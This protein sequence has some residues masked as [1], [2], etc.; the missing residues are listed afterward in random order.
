MSKKRRTIHKPP[1]IKDRVESFKQTISDWRAAGF[2]IAD[3]ERHNRRLKICE[4]CEFYKNIPTGFICLKC[5]C[6]S[7]KLWL[8]TSKCPINKW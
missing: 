8:Q 2:P 6:Y 5:G 7:V 4:R 3:K 1:P